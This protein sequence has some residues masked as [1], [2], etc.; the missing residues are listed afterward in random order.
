[1][2][3]L[4]ALLLCCFLLTGCG[5]ETAPVPEPLPEPT[6]PAALYDSG[7]PME[8]RHP[9]ALR[10]YPLPMGDIL[11]IRTWGTDLLVFSGYSKT[12]LTRLSG[13][14]LQIT[15]SIQLDHFLAPEDPTLHISSGGLSFF[16]PSTRETVI[17][18]STLEE[19]SRIAAPQDMVGTPIL[20]GDGA[21]LYYCTSNAIRAWN[22]DS[23]IRRM[24]KQISFP[25]QS[26]TGL[27]RNDTMLECSVT[28]EGGT[29]APC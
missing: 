12:T 22:L 26:L 6:A 4:F 16:D 21:N 28:D 10:T 7:S 3:H 13:D 14:E 24:L 25:A 11:G 8:L 20:S 29:P 18:S 27:H 5:A 23:G 19:T 2:K 1:M 15:A 9:E 17:L